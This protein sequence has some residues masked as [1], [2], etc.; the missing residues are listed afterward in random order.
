MNDHQT[1]EHELKRLKTEFYRLR[2]LY[3]EGIISQREYVAELKKLRVR[4]SEGKFWTIGAQSGE[5][6]YFNGR[7]WIRAEP[8]ISGE[9][10]E[11][12][13][14]P[15]ASFLE[16]PVLAEKSG[17][18]TLDF[19]LREK[20]FRISPEVARLEADM[21]SQNLPE[22]SEKWVVVSLPFGSSTLFFG[23]MGILLGILTGAVAGST[24]FFLQTFSFLPLFLQEIMGK[25][26]GGII[27]AALGG[28]A[29]FIGGCGLGFFISL[30]FNLTASLTGGLAIKAGL[31]KRERKEKK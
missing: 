22:K 4:D 29:G 14:G 28:V 5:W 12:E 30:I 11:E 9:I 21:D 2:H 17:G 16:G 7:N 19:N 8:P 3:L 23:G 15:P 10:W 20:S 26:T 18:E 31:E 13:A 27:F 25:L 1:L 6:Y 24:R